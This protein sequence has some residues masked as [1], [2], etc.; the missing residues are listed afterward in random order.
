MLRYLFYHAAAMCRCGW[1]LVAWQVALV[2][3]S[4]ADAWA[5]QPTFLEECRVLRV[6]AMW[7]KCLES[8]SVRVDLKALK[9]GD[10]AYVQYVGLGRTLIAHCAAAFV[11]VSAGRWCL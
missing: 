7:C 2:G 8:F 1:R 4:T 5:N 10:E 3:M 11:H 6:D 9:R